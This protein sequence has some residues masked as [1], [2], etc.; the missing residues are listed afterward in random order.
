MNLEPDVLVIGGGPAGL[1]AAAKAAAGGAVVTLLERRAAIGE[2]VRSSGASFIPDLVK[3]GVSADCYH[4]V[5]VLKFVSPGETAT[6]RYNKPLGCVLDVR[7]L[8]QHLAVEAIRAG[9]EIHLKTVV[10]ELTPAREG[11]LLVTARG[12]SRQVMEFRPRLVIDASGFSA[13]AAKRT[14]LHHGF[15]RFAVGAEYDFFAPNYDQDE[16]LLLVGS[17][18]VPAGYGWAFPYGEGRVRVGVGIIYP[19]ARAQVLPYL[20][21]LV[22]HLKSTSTMLHGAAPVEYHTGVIPARA[23]TGTLSGGRVLI[24][25]DAAA[26]AS[27]LLGEGIRFSLGAGQLAGEAAVSALRQD[28]F[29]DACLEQLYGAVWRQRYGRHMRIASEIQNVIVNYRDEHWDARVRMLRRLTP[30]L[31]AAALGTDFRL[32]V[33]AGIAARNPELAGAGLR[34]L[35][36]IARG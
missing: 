24:A 22:A 26:Q 23:F 3:L 34:R 17:H 2:P 35:I 27:P 18:I 4:P 11:R 1:G 10:L 5:P 13:V 29:S 15:P 8:Y 14:G 25:G 28:D 9:A 32:S 12:I 31:F 33:L 36:R 20:E 21:K 30:K 7:K 16:A 6:F 19:N